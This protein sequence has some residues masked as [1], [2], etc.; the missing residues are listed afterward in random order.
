MLATLSAID[1]ALCGHS[2]AAWGL[3]QLFDKF[4]SQTSVLSKDSFS[5][6]AS[7]LQTD[8][9]FTSNIEESQL[10]KW[11]TNVINNP[12][13]S[14]LTPVVKCFLS[15]FTGPRVESSFSVMNNIITSSTNRICV[16][17]KS[18]EAIHKVKYQ[19]LNANKSSVE[20]YERADPVFSPVDVSLVHHIQTA[21]KRIHSYKPSRPKL[22]RIPKN[23][24]VHQ[25]SR[26]LKDKMDSQ[27]SALLPSDTS[28]GVVSKRPLPSPS[29]PAPKRHC[30]PD[31]SKKTIQ[32]AIQVFWSKLKDKQ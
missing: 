12:K 29:K 18:Y 30:H 26:H 28:D 5:L 20:L 13:Y 3:N 16:K 17:T 6:A 19:L 9:Q 25:Q 23:Q 27:V 31:L 15:I 11:W 2:K 22:P 24:T 14:V 4:V 8:Q 10:D 32:P 21:A 1:P 7:Q